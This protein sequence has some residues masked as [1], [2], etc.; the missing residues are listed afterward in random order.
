MCSRKCETPAWAG[1]SSREPVLTHRPSA[2]ERTEGTTS[3]TTRTPD[4]SSVSRL[5]LTP[6]ALAPAAAAATLAVAALPVAA[7]TATAAVAGAHRNQLLRLLPLNRGVIGEPQAD[8]P[9]LAID[10]DHG[11]V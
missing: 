3:V 9:A 7:V 4:S 5:S 1:V 10:F 11:H 8:P 2:T 6:A